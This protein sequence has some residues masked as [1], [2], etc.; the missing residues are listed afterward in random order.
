[1]A[2]LYRHD[3]Y[4][5]NS[6]LYIL[7]DVISYRS[8]LLA[9]KLTWFGYFFIVIIITI[10]FALHDKIDFPAHEKNFAILSCLAVVAG[11]GVLRWEGGTFEYRR[12]L[13]VVA[14]MLVIYGVAR[15]AAARIL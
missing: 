10:Y 6:I 9:A 14:V 12:R 15:Y 3:F 2:V 7:W 4:T 5:I 8:T 11:I 1:V 13:I